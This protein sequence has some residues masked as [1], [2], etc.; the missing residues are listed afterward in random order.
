MIIQILIFQKMILCDEYIN[1][2]TNLKKFVELLLVN[3]EQQSD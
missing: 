1:D 3:C 2:I